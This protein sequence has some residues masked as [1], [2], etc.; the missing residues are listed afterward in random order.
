MTKTE[1]IFELSCPFAT[2]FQG[3]Q[4]RMLFVCSAGLL[5]S[6][7]AAAE[8]IKLGYNSRSCG[9]AEYALIP[10]SVNL[11]EW[12]ETIYFLNDYNYAEALDTF[13]ALPEYSNMLQKKAVIWD[14]LDN[15]DYGDPSLIHQVNHLLTN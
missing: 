8:A 1:Q 12:A 14:I 9:S 13:R 10:L 4:H 2:P 11:I 6:P 3:K 7:T 15:Y 5:R